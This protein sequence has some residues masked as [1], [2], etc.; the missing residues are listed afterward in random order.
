MKSTIAY[1]FAF[2]AVAAVCTGSVLGGRE[3]MN[4]RIAAIFAALFPTVICF[5][6]EA[7]P[8]TKL[9]EAARAQVGVT[10]VYDPA[11]VSLSY[12]GGDVPIDRGVC[13]DVII[14]ALRASLNI[15]L[16][17]TVHED[18]A[19]HFSLYPTVWGLTK[20]D[21]N[22]DH[23]RVPNLR[24]YFRRHA[25]FLKV[26]KQPSAYQPGDLVTSMLPKNLPHV[27]IVSDKKNSSGVPLVIHNIGRGAREQDCLFTYPITGH[28]RLRFR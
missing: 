3:Q 10:T 18:M 16:Q 15:D 28:Y 25:I 6:Q 11:Y 22:I 1:S 9:V 23:R 19:S 2:L 4:R 12:P 17:R 24:T 5:A 8:Q 26:S 13:T 27:M 7:T 21:K 20:P 14:R